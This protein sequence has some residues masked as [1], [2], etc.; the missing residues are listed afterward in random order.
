MPVML[1][2]CAE[3]MLQLGNQLLAGFAAQILSPQQRMRRQTISAQSATKLGTFLHVQQGL[4]QVLLL[5]LPCLLMEEGFGSLVLA[6][7]WVLKQEAAA[8]QD[9]QEGLL[10][11]RQAVLLVAAPQAELPEFQFEEKVTLVPPAQMLAIHIKTQLPGRPVV[12]LVPQ[13]K[14]VQLRLSECQVKEKEAGRSVGGA[15]LQSMPQRIINAKT[16]L[17]GD[18][19]GLMKEQIAQVVAYVKELD[20]EVPVTISQQ[21]AQMNVCFAT[22]KVRAA[23]IKADFVIDVAFFVGLSRIMLGWIVLGGIAFSAI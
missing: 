19:G 13:A 4:R 12:R 9:Q 14:A 16:V 15:L 6:R 2:D 17:V 22:L 1:Q 8:L 21:C 23:G 3:A 10:P 7:L 20:E 18:A 5:L 11:G